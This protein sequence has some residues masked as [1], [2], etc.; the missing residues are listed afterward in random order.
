M[1]L[2][3]VIG[4]AMIRMIVV[5]IVVMIVVMTVVMIIMIVLM[6]VVMIVVMNDS[7]TSIRGLPVGTHFPSCHKSIVALRTG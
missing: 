7:H 5:I 3:I 6:I 1:I 2:V 4:M